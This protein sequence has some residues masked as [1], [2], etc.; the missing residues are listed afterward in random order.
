MDPKPGML[1]SIG[2]RKIGDYTVESSDPYVLRE[3]QSEYIKKHA[4]KNKYQLAV[5]PTGAGKSLLMM[6]YVAYR[7]KNKKKNV[8]LVPKLSIATGFEQYIADKEFCA[9]N[10]RRKFTLP[11]LSSR[12]LNPTCNKAKTIID[13][14]EQSGPKLIICA[15]P[16][17]INIYDKLSDKT[18]QELSIIL[19]EGHHSAVGDD[20]ESTLIGSIIQKAHKDDIGVHV[21]T[22]TDFRSDGTAILPDGADF[23]VYR[24]TLL[25]HYQDGDCPDFGFYFRFYDKVSPKKYQ[26]MHSDTISDDVI[27]G[28]ST[29]LLS[30]Y[31]D[32]YNKHK[33]PTLM[34]IPQHIRASYRHSMNS[35]YAAKRLQDMLKK[36]NPDIRILNL[37]SEDGKTYESI[38]PGIREK[39][40]RLSSE[41]F[42]VVISIKVADEGVD[43]RDCSQ[44]FFPRVPGSLGLIYQRTGRALRKKPK[45]HPHRDYSRVVFFELDIEQG[46]HFEVC[47][48]LFKLA[49]RM[50]AIYHGLDWSQP[51]RLS[52]PK[53]I[54]RNID[55]EKNKLDSMMQLQIDQQ[56]TKIALTINDVNELI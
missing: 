53:K 46:E 19:D 7:Y 33:Q 31:V 8:I 24:R 9:K 13:V 22:A 52:L 11:I 34:I 36:A 51:F 40:E 44:V 35:A 20:K 26:N 25:E 10:G 6:T 1:S 16:S 32:E 45:D 18:K 2:H 5:L 30:T 47:P 42:D 27:I 17:F 50:K 15:Y 3:Y 23:N 21:Y 39:Y 48:A 37:G 55:L 14:L 56:I 54:R 12:Q 38:K 49:V 41:K 43:W 29:K 4:L 28:N